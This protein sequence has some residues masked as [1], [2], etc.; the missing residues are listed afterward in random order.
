[1]I[2]TPPAVSMEQI[3]KEIHGPEG[4]MASMRSYCLLSPPNYVLELCDELGQCGIT[5]NIPLERHRIRGLF[6]AGLSPD[7]GN[8]GQD[9]RFASVIMTDFNC[10]DL[11]FTPEMDQLMKWV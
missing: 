11:E 3:R 5:S 4:V 10:E 1:M 7:D 8:G 6:R 2:T 9:R